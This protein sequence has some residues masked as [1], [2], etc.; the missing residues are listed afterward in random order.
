MN[1]N[2]NCFSVLA[3][4]AAATTV[5]ATALPAQA[6]SLDGTLNFGGNISVSGGPDNFQYDFLDEGTNPSLSPGTAGDIVLGA[7]T[8]SFTT[9]SEVAVGAKIQDFSTL[10]AVPDFPSAPIDNFITGLLLGTKEVSFNLV[11]FAGSTGFFNILA[12]DFGLNGG[13]V[14]GFFTDGSGETVGVGSLTAQFSTDEVT[15]LT[16]YS[17]SL[18]AKPVPT[19]ALLPGLIGM[20]FATLRK[21]KVAEQEA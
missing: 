7:S 2:I 3:A 12:N 20:G 14:E 10:F 18:Q 9:V 17:A 13:A 1:L 21:R 5:V 4:S 11:G 15:G 6:L 16:T 19:P 8:G